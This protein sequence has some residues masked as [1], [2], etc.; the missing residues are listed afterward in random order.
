MLKPYANSQIYIVG[1]SPRHC[2]GCSFTY[3]QAGF[4]A[5]T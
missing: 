2:F 4:P 5:A 3:H 1:Y